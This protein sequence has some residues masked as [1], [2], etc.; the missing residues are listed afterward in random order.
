MSKH[1][2]HLNRPVLLCIKLQNE[3][4]KA[5]IELH[6]NVNVSGPEAAWDLKGDDGH[7]DFIKNANV[8]TDSPRKKNCS[9]CS[10]Q[11]LCIHYW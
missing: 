5:S 1:K 10:Y 11:I 8:L 7:S 3:Q 9:S 4:I 6:C 2:N